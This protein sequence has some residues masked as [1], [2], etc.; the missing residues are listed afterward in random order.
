M[1]RHAVD[2]AGLDALLADPA[3]DARIRLLA[4]TIADESRTNI[5]SMQA[6]ESGALRDSGSVSGERST[7]RVGYGTDHAEIVHEG[8]SE[9][10]PR[11]FLASAALKYRGRLP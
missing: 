11:P 1:G 2:K 9:M 5:T 10:P 7:Y 3:V 8:T 4:Q 6:V